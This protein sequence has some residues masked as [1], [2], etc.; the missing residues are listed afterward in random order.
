MESYKPF[1]AAFDSPT[2]MAEPE[3]LKRPEPI[4]PNSESK[5]AETLTSKNPEGYIGSLDVF[6]HEARDIQNI[7]IYHK[8][9]V[10]AKIC[11]TSD[12]DSSVS[13]Q[14]IN[15]G[16]RNPVF[17][18]NLQLNVR[19]IDSSLK[20]EVWMLSRV[21]NYLEDQLL[22]FALVPLSDVVVANGKLVEEFSL[23]STDLFHSP[24]G[25]IQLSISYTGALPEVLAITPREKS[26]N[27]MENDDG[28]CEL[29]KIEF[30]DLKV[31]NENKMMVSEYYGIPCD[32]LDSECTKELVS[33]ESDS[34]PDN[35]AGGEPW[36]DMRFSWAEAQV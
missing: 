23:S 27:D 34:C 3:K 29:D 32:N 13:T 12:P 8:Q 10:Y 26:S 28:G 5:S 22:G 24:S 33:A 25:F 16:G 31:V 14:T 6:I 21:K 20:C 9:D 35:E 17:N 2:A 15:G 7:C 30:P 1:S 19:T 4:K 18:Q 11:L 36:Q